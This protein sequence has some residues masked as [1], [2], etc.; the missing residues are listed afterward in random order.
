MATGRR[1]SRS[2]TSGRFVSRAAAARW[3]N[4]TLA[5]EEVGGDRPKTRLVNRSAPT[6]RFVKES[7]VERHPE[8]TI[9]QQ[10]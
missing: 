5:A 2:A 8:S 4:R 9:T 7:T 1:V 6:G 3:P 10:V